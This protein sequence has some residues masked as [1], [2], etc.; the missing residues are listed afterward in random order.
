MAP[1]RVALIGALLVIGSLLL[2][3]CSAPR[4]PRCRKICER[5]AECAEHQDDKDFKFDKGECVA[6]CTALERD[7]QGILILEKHASC[8]EK[9]RDCSEVYECE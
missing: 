8:V 9:A 2:A 7:D 1:V 3:G 5:E 6:A 4:S